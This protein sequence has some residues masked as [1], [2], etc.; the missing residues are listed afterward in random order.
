MNITLIYNEEIQSV[1][2]SNFKDLSS[3]IESMFDIPIND[4]V[5][6]LNDKIIHH[7]ITNGDLLYIYSKEKISYSHLHILGTNANYKFKLI[8]DSG[9][10]NN[11]I[12]T[13]L[14]NLL[15]LSIDTRTKG[16]ARGVGSAKIVGNANCHLKI[17]QHYYN[18][19]FS[20]METSQ[21]LTSKYLVLIGLD[22]LIPYGCEISF[23][24][25]TM[26][27]QDDVIPFLNDYEVNKYTHPMK[28]E[29]PLEIHYKQLNL[30]LDEHLMLKKI[31]NN[32]IC[33]PH[34][35]KYKLINMNS[36][37]FQKHLSKC[38]PFMKELGFVE[39]DK[40]L[41][42]TNDIDTLSNLIEIM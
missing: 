32:I 41:K 13:H 19:S 1:Q 6:K 35:D 31:I 28:M 42:Y 11:V 22:F 8:I 38:K 9:A 12:S 30:S 24:N 4:Q 2:L 10:Q 40:Q 14:A 7:N 26:T 29:N 23:K 21:D 20:V 27:I 34:D 16:E 3:I 5:I 17:D 15:N 25:K 36:M 37:T 33:N 39:M 18:L